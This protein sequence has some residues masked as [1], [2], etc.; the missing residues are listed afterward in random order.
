MIVVRTGA[1]SRR[2][3]YASVE[4]LSSNPTVCHVCSSPEKCFPLENFL[5]FVRKWKSSGTGSL[6]RGLVGDNIPFVENEAYGCRRSRPTPRV[7]QSLD[8]LTVLWSYRLL[9]LEARN[10]PAGLPLPVQ[11]RGGHDLANRRNGFELLGRYPGKRDGKQNQTTSFDLRRGAV[12][13]TRS[14]S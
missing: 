6:T 13:L 4:E 8:D 9:Q 11:N 12:S 3:L 2:L 10:P 14:I 1:L 7:P 5:S